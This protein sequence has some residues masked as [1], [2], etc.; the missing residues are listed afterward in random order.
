MTFKQIAGYL[1]INAAS[2][3]YGIRVYL[4]SENKDLPPCHVFDT[5]KDAVQAYGDKEIDNFGKAVH[6]CNESVTFWL[7]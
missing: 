5:L 2:L 3:E 6:I 7:Q 1:S 4:W